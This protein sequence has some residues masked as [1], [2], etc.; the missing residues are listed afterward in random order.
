MLIGSG[1]GGTR[2]RNTYVANAVS[3]DGTNDWLSKASDFTGAADG[4]SFTLSMWVKLANTT[5]AY[6]LWSANASNKLDLLTT[7]GGKFHFIGRNYAGAD[8]LADANMGT[9][10]TSWQHIQIAADLANSVAYLYLNDVLAESSW[11][12]GPTNDALDLTPGGWGVGAR[13][14]GGAKLNGDMADVWFHD[15]FI[16]ISIE[17]NRRKFIDYRG[18]PVYLGPT[19]SIP[20]GSQPIV[21][22]GNAFSTWHNNLGSGGDLVANGSLTAAATSPS[23]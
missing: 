21:Y 8:I 2:Q 4:K 19:G 17:A 6:R 14:D 23:G 18:R 16:D 12:T 15:T 3:F 1:N 20:T 10:S 22:L 5:T 7:V 11:D 9:T 13:Q